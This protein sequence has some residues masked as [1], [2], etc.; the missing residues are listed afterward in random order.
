VLNPQYAVADTSQIISPGLVLFR[1]L[2]EANLDRM[3][4]IAGSPARLRPHC[5]THKMREVIELQLA[6]G[7]ARHKCATLAEA[8]MLAEA[9]A[10][11]IFLAYNPVGPN[12]GRVAAFVKKYPRVKFAVTADHPRPVAALGGA[13]ASFG[14]TVD[15]L[16]DID[17]GLHRTGIACGPAA[18]EL[19]RQISTT[20][21]LAAGGFH[22]YDGHNHQR[23]VAERRAAVLAVWQ[24][25]AALRDEV[26]GAGMSVPRIV[27]GGTASFPI[28]ATLEDPTIELSPGTIVLQDFGYGDAFPDLAFQPAAL[29]LTRV[30]SR[31]TAERIT[32]DL[33]YKAVAA[34]SPLAGRVRFPDLPDARLVLQNEEHL[35][36]ETAAAER[37]AP[38][39][40]LWAIPKH[41]CPTSALYKAAYVVAGGKLVGTWAVAARDRMLTV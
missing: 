10:Q 6:R 18:R 11:D 41:I 15:V 2:I 12:I 37:Y 26:A 33:G 19:Y 17:T 38:G 30:I 1:D 22:L 24:P 8:E 36:V 3:I 16:L 40:E 9:G 21:G 27:A 20:K 29:L 34:E 35:V 28:F 13:L 5:K 7:I 14:K 4:H 23:D 31:P 32:L 39:D 25:A